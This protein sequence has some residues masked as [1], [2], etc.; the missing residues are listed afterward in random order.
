MS[1]AAVPPTYQSRHEIETKEEMANDNESNTS[2]GSQYLQ[3]VLGDVLADALS[4]VAKERPVDPIQYVADYL[5]GLKASN[6]LEETFND[7]L[8]IKE[9]E[10]EELEQ[11]ID[12]FEDRTSSPNE[13]RTTQSEP[14]PSI[15]GSSIFTDS[16]PGS[17]TSN[18]STTI[19]LEEDEGPLRTSSLDRNQFPHKAQR[20]GNRKS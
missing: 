8:D 16:N 7:S 19:I 5:H 15:Q 12:E 1:S 20:R 14:P 10:P 18:T 9:D 3:E 4:K 13:K 11:G 2:T 6:P 17:S